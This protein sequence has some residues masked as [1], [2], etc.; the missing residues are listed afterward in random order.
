MLKVA[1]RGLMAHKARLI[2]TFAAVALGVAFMGGVLV[3]TDTMNR[4]FDDLFADVFRDTDA[5]VR[6]DQTFEGDFGDVRGRIDAAVLPDVEAADGVKAAAPGI[7][8]Y[9]QIIDK[10]GDAVGDPASR[11][12]TPATRSATTCRCRQAE[13]SARSSSWASCASARRTAPVARR[14]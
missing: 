7:D 2:T 9:A 4:S 8:G 5:V 13:A 10:D 11:P 6:S 14:T 3:L 12:R 1:L